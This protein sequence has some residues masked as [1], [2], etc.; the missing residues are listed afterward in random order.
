MDSSDV[1]ALYIILRAIFDMHTNAV[2]V[3]CVI[4]VRGLYV[5]FTELV[6]MSFEFLITYAI[7]SSMF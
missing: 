4:L 7:F 6:I 1:Q 2:N 3:L 5:S